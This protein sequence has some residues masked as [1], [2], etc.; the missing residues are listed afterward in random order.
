MSARLDKVIRQVKAVMKSYNEGSAIHDHLDDGLRH[1]TKANELT[2]KPKA[3][4]KEND[5]PTGTGK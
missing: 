1:L 3:A 4:G 2:E 5:E